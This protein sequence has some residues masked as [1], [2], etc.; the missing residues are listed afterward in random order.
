MLATAQLE[1]IVYKELKKKNIYLLRAEYTK[2]A[3]ILTVYNSLNFTSNV[4]KQIVYYYNRG[5]SFK[6]LVE[7]FGISEVYMLWFLKN[8]G[9]QVSA[10]RGIVFNS[11]KNIN[12]SIILFIKY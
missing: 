4:Q 10:L 6:K 5:M 8:I 9:I 3:N 12:I 11:I 2:K 1:S 7:K